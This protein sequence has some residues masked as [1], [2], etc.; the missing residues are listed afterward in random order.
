MPCLCLCV[1]A[2]DAQDGPASNEPWIFDLAWHGRAEFNAAKR[3]LWR[4]DLPDHAPESHAD[5]RL[6]EEGASR[7]GGGAESEGRREQGKVVGYR[8]EHS[9]LRHVV[10][11]N[12]GHMVSP[13]MLGNAL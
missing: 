11:R 4:L 1:G 5:G 8:R 3:E 10:I 2:T 7:E 12:A 6:L 9:T 13:G